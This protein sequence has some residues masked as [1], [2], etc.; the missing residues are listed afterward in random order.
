MDCFFLTET[1]L[2]T[3]APATLIEGGSSFIQ[4]HKSRDV[5]FGTFYSFEYN[6]PYFSSDNLQSSKLNFAI[7]FNRI[8]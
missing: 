1:W 8:L 4:R 2:G 6:V 3:D 5:D 7:V